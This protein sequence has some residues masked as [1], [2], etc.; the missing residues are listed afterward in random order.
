M[1]PG[2][3]AHSYAST[4]VGLQRPSLRLW[5]SPASPSRHTGSSHSDRTASAG[6]F[7]VPTKQDDRSSRC[8]IAARGRAAPAPG[9]STDVES[10]AQRRGNDGQK[11]PPSLRSPWLIS[12]SSPAYYTSLRI[13]WDNQCP[14]SQPISKSRNHQCSSHSHHSKKYGT[15]PKCPRRVGTI[16]LIANI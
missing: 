4:S 8:S 16:S 11:K 15:C 2:R 9:S 14:K 10:D 6:G 7:V 12:L 3:S 5:G 1:P 13:S